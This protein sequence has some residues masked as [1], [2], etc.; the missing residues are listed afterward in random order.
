[1]PLYCNNT[2]CYQLYCDERCNILQL[3]PYSAAA[4][5]YFALQYMIYCWYWPL[6][7]YIVPKSISWLW[8]IQLGLCMIWIHNAVSAVKTNAYV[9]STCNMIAYVCCWKLWDVSPSD[10]WLMLILIFDMLYIKS[11]VFWV[12]EFRSPWKQNDT[13]YGVYADIS[14]VNATLLG[15]YHWKI[16]NNTFVFTFL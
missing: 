16:P 12:P 13:S 11:T 8:V 5:Y 3:N 14:I 9:D 1:M 4:Q 6:L 2:C 10:T 15:L 7:R